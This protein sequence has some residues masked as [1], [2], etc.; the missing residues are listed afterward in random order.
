MVIGSRSLEIIGNTASRVWMGEENRTTWTMFLVLLATGLVQIVFSDVIPKGE[1]F[2]F[3][4]H[5]YVEIV[6]HFPQILEQLNPY[7]FQR[8]LP[9]SLLHY[10]VNIF[11][12]WPGNATFLKLFQGYNLFMILIAVWFWSRIASCFHLSRLMR[13][14]GFVLMFGSYALLEM[15]FF[16]PVSSDATIFALGMMIL[17]AYIRNRL[18]LLGFMILLAGFVWPFL[19]ITANFLLLFPCHIRQRRRPRFPWGG[20]W[21]AFFVMV[22]AAVFYRVVYQEMPEAFA[23]AFFQSGWSPIRIYH[24]ALTLSVVLALG[25]LFF[26]LRRLLHIGWMG[27][28][29]Y[30]TLWQR[31]LLF[32]R[33]WMRLL[34]VLVIMAIHERTV[35]L[36]SQPNGDYWLAVL[37][38][39]PALS[40]IH[41]P[42]IGAV[43]HTIYFGPLI[44]L[45]FFLWPRICRNL[46]LFG[47]GVLLYA[48]AM[49]WCGLNAESRLW[50]FFIPFLGAFTMLSLDEMAVQRRSGWFL[51][52]VTLLSSK[53]WLSVQFNFPQSYYMGIRLV[54]A[55]V[56]LSKSFSLHSNKH[57]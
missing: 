47:M 31:L 52:G 50:I 16:N 6:Q 5:R 36:Y 3:D 45:A 44:I 1:G 19:A 49:V 35:C 55:I 8:V 37:L 4:G 23:H 2:G 41:F 13:W 40:S 11:P 15:P 43:S 42:A 33:G 30:D 34:L 25:Y 20:V 32:R 46:R 28:G 17:Y 38:L 18:L 29:R 21:A 9:F 48:T 57:A 14:L 12:E 56:Q 51:A 27:S 24:P 54:Q 53:V 39:D 26:A 10:L 7:Y 22:L